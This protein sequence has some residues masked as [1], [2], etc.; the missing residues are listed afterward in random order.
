MAS[1]ENTLVVHREIFDDPLVF[2]DEM[3]KMRGTS[4]R[5]W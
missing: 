1:E 5:S 2:A 3:G 4:P